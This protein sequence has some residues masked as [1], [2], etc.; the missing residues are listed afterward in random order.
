M[1][2]KKEVRKRVYIS[3]GSHGK[4]FEFSGGR[5]ADMYPTLLWVFDKKITDDL[6]PATIIYKVRTK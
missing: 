5:V 2:K 1:T 3:V 4:I 6:I